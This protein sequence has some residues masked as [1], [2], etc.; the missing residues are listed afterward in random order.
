MKTVQIPISKL[1]N[2]LEKMSNDNMETV[3]LTINEEVFDQNMYYPAFIHMEAF[4]KDGEVRDY[5]TLDSTM[6]R[7]P[8]FR[9]RF[10]SPKKVC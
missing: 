8:S 6:I 3:M 7:L 2:V 9:K 5:D 1:L 10:K 4:T